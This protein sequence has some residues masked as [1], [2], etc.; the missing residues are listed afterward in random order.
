LGE[1]TQKLRHQI[2]RRQEAQQEL[3]RAHDELES[4]VQARTEDLR[5][6]NLR[7]QS[8]NEERKRA[9]KAL[10]F[11]QFSVD[12]TSDALFWLTRDARLFYVN[13]AACRS[14]GYTR[15]ELLSMSVPDFDPQF[16]IEHWDTHWEKIKLK[17]AASIETWHRR[18]DGTVFPVEIDIRF[19]EFEGREYHFDSVRDITERKRLEDQLRHAQK[20][21]A[22]GSLAGGVAHDFNNLLA[23]ILGNAELLQERL[24]EDDRSTQA[25]IRASTR[26]AE[27]TQ[28]LLA[29]SRR[30]PLQPKVVDLGGFVDGMT[31]MLSRTLGETIEVKTVS[32]P[33]LWPT[34]ADPG[35][36]ENALL[37]LAINARHAMP[38]GGKLIIESANVAFDDDYAAAQEEVRPGDYVMLAVSDTGH[39]IAPAVLPHVFE[40]FFTTKDV[41]EGSGLG[42]SM[43]YG[44]AKQ[45]AGHVTIFSEPDRGTTVKL[46]LPRAGAAAGPRESRPA[47][48]VPRCRGETVLVV[49]D[50]PDVRK[51]AVAYLRTLG[52]EVIEAADAEAALAALTNAPRLQLLLSDVVLPGGMNGPDLAAEVQS[53]RPETKVLYMSGYPEHTIAGHSPLDDGAELINKPFRQRDLAIK[54]RAVLDEDSGAALEARETLAAGIDPVGEQ[55][56]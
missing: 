7:L 19:I 16:P 39:G 10:R 26:G 33:D 23:V 50:D 8:E 4:R 2:A 27:L 14:L 56:V 20:M 24:G 25:L 1:R 36:V 51:L 35:Q 43:V 47:A 54:L 22:I 34:V 38:R 40:P 48:A 3:H 30:Q 15:D 37:N 28:R 31:G 9:E 29:F 55:P 32:A 42:L 46:Y 18:K 5:L 17:G 49:E 53:R 12:S 6:A 11:A 41:G 21:E 13:E 52:Y 44:F 45:S